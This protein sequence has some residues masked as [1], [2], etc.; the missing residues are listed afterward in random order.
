MQKLAKK[1][2]LELN[3]DYLEIEK[4]GAFD[5][6]YSN[7]KLFVDMTKT[8]YNIS[9]E[10]SHQIQQQKHQRNLCFK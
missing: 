9:T 5:I 2:S 7:K 8:N 3:G 1:W 10:L 6:K 4:I